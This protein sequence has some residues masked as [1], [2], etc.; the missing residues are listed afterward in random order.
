MKIFLLLLF[1]LASFSIWLGTSVH[2]QSPADLPI[3]AGVLADWKYEK[4]IELPQIEDSQFVEVNFDEEVF[5]NVSPG[6][7]DIRVVALSPVPREVPY[8]LVVETSAR[9]RVR[10]SGRV[11]DVSL[12]PG[13]YSSFTVDLGRSGLFHNEIDIQS[14]SVNFR[15]EVTVEGSNDEAEWVILQDRGIIY[16]YTDPAAGLKARN[17]SVR[18]PESTLRYLRVRV[19]N[20]DEAPLAVSGAS[21]FFEKTTRA[22]T[23]SYPAQIIDV[24]D[25]PEHRA[26]QILFDL[27]SVGLPNNALSLTTSDVNFQRNIALEAGNTPEDLRVMKSR[28]VIFS[29]QTPKFT[30]SKLQV[31]YPESTRR[32]LR[33]TIFNKDDAP[34]TIGSASASG[35]LR[36]LVFEANP[37]ESYTL[38][39][40]NS[41]ARYPQYDLEKYFQYLETENLR[42]AMLGAQA[43][44]RFFV[45]EAPLAVPAAD[46]YPWLLPT[47]LGLA[48]AVLLAFL[49]R[50]FLSVRKKL[51]PMSER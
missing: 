21:V 10:L 12:L 25:V 36:K 28:D 35:I 45:Q 42:Q 5:A 51:P 1:P 6:L 2:A 8:Q 14:G 43:A 16:D 7:R 46:R 29:F 11:F 20:R 30:G 27:G 13:A 9:E 26:T 17:T 3:G 19:A 34:I 32:Y 41:D 39:Y 37:E 31:S 23:V 22:K 38:F 50:L 48:I 49:V 40:G 44:S 33:L 24:S 18:Y 15:R 47:A 4:Q